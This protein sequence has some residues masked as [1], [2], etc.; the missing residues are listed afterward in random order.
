MVK[1][2]KYLGYT[3]KLKH[4]PQYSEWLTTIRDSDNQTIVSDYQKTEEEAREWAQNI[5]RNINSVD[6]TGISENA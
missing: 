6:N 1:D 4:L 2:E 5:I 3:I